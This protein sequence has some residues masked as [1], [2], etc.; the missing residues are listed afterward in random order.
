MNLGLQSSEG[1]RRYTL[2]SEADKHPI[3]NP[4]ENRKLLILVFREVRDF[5]SMIRLAL[6]LVH[7]YVASLECQ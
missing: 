2:G 7:L 6:Q 3:I 4:A 1:R 5:V